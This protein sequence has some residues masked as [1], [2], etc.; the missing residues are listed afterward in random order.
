MN[1]LQRA[2]DEVPSACELQ[3]FRESQLS[4]P[5]INWIPP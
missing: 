3:V 2:I 5:Q 1:T 4:L